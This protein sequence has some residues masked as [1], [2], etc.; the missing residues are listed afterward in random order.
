LV[1][2]RGV[3]DSVSQ[4]VPG[5]GNAYRRPPR[6]ARIGKRGAGRPPESVTRLPVK[7]YRP[8]KKLIVQLGSMMIYVVAQD[9]GLQQRELLV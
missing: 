3:A 1:P 7:G 6:T 9:A 4:P 2:L 8:V 5:T